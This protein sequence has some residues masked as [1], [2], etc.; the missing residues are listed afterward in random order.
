MDVLEGV[1]RLF[2]K[3]IDLPWNH[4][5]LPSDIQ[6]KIIIHFIKSN[7]SSWRAYEC[8]TYEDKLE[9]DVNIAQ[10]LHVE[11]FEIDTI[12]I[13]CEAWPYDW[14]IITI[15]CI[16]VRN[17]WLKCKKN[18]IFT[19]LYDSVIFEEV[20]KYFWIDKI[21]FYYTSHFIKGYYPKIE[22]KVKRF[23]RMLDQYN[24]EKIHRT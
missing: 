6:E 4:S 16:Q 20:V 10:L 11:I 15:N 2:I 8:Y 21:I 23:T 12:N 19:T 18:K 22:A 13:I 24:K 17:L 9:I 3:N 14:P 5:Y 7:P 1:K